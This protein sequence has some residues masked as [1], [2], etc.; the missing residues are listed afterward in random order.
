MHWQSV[1]PN[2]YLFGD[3][4]NI[5]AV[6]GPEG[7]LIIDAGTGKWLEHLDELPKKPV[8]LACTHYF[9]DH[10]A[11]AVMA[12]RAGIPVFVPEGEAGIFADPAE[13]FRRRETY[14][15]YDCLWD[16]FAPIE[17]VKVAGVLRD[18]EKLTLAGL[19]VEVIPQPG[20]TITQV[21]LA[22]KIPGGRRVIFSAETIHSPGKVARVAPLQYNYNDLGGALNVYFSAHVLREHAADALLPSLGIPMLEG[23]DDALAKVQQTMKDLCRN[24][25]G[26]SEQF[27]KVGLEPMHKITEHVYQSGAGLANTWFILSDSGKVLAIDYGYN[28]FLGTYCWPAQ[29]KPTTRRALLHSLKG[30]KQ[31][32]GRDRIDTVLLSHFHEDHTCGVPLLQRLFGTQVWAADNFADLVEFPERHCFPC[33]W[34]IPMKVDRRLPVDMSPVRWE[35]YTFRLAPM[36]GHTRFAAL[37]AF[38]ADR[39]RFAHTGD[40]YFFQNRTADAGYE[41]N[42]VMR[43]YVFRNGALIDGYERSGRWMLE[44]RPDIVI[45]GH[46]PA[47]ITDGHFFARIE[48]FSKEYREMHEAAMPLGADETHFNLDGWGGWIWPYHTRQK[49]SGP[50]TVRV[51]VRNPLPRAATLQVR[52][53]GP[54]GW[55][56]TSTLFDAEA[57]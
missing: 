10:A 19:E 21:G 14:I 42:L 24:R 39:K 9:R 29:S 45:Q 38:E 5:Y 1:L 15:I 23:T 3:S 49:S 22:V 25:P 11:G 43:N 47:M 57:R 13:H 52:L 7:M 26:M 48:D 12:Q 46:Q 4:C 55:K 20:V 31:Q 27:E 18:Y 53:V 30:L 17:P 56:G 16:L 40:Q 35:E 33:N 37:I 54:K 6:A 41:N 34:H 50:A 44:Y 28:F 51:T 36:D 2:V 32:L 8:A